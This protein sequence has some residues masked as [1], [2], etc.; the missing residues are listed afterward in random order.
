MV[1]K[2]PR[3][4]AKKTHFGLTSQQILDTGQSPYLHDRHNYKWDNPS[5]Q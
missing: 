1:E 4:A 2:Y 3:F 5:R